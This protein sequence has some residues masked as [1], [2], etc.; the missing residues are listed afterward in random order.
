MRTI[1]SEMNSVEAFQQYY[2]KSNLMT[3][4]KSCSSFLKNPY[5]LL[6]KSGKSVL[7]K[8]LNFK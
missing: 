4:L 8:Y 6:L 1:I 5:K 2:E 3:K 7:K